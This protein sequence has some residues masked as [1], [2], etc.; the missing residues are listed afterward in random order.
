[1]K[2]L[3]GNVSVDHFGRLRL[4]SA[5]HDSVLQALVKE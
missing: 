1:M 2:G 4:R 3:G 5:P